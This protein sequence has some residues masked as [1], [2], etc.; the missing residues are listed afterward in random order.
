MVRFIGVDI[1]RRNDSTAIVTIEVGEDGIVHV[2]GIREL[3]DVPFE[4]QVAE[5][6]RLVQKHDARLVAVDSTG[7]GL[8]IAETLKRELSGI[9]EAVSFTAPSKAELVRTSVAVL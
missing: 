9:V 3:K 2:R 5:I 1:G 8:P 6:K 7:M 4:A